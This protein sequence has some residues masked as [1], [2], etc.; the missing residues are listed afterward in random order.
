MLTLEHIEKSFHQETV[1]HPVTLTVT[2]GNI[3]SIVGPSGCG[4]TT[5]LRCVAGFLK[6]DG[7]EMY[8]GDSRLDTKKAAERPVVLMFQ[9]AL[10]F[11]HLT[12]SEN[13]AYGL[14]HGRRRLS[15]PERKQETEAMLSRVGLWEKRNHY[16]RELSGGQQQRVSLARALL[17]QPDLLLLDEPFSSLDAH[18]RQE[19]RLWVRDFLKEEGVTALFVTHDREEA[20]I[21]GDRMLVM[22]RGH[23]LQEGT[24]EDVH[25]RPA[26]PDVAAF[27]GE[28]IYLDGTYYP[29]SSLEA[30]SEGAA[31]VVEHAVY[32]YG[33]TFYRIHLEADGQ[34][35]VIR[36][37]E[38]LTPGQKLAVRPK[39]GVSDD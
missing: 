38:S 6:P 30:A 18:L 1:L 23:V 5:L 21:M 4:K 7:G 9:D 10:L 25:K 31:A 33:W 32:A 34:Q 20:A 27:I 36:S 28:G 37:E 35:T 16:P 29:G 2:A 8:L 3:L 19:L 15:R 14:R 12:V 26:G 39:E 17:L 13:A 22:Q 11:P 24:P